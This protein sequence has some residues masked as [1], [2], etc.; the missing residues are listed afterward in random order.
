MRAVDLGLLGWQNRPF[1]GR[2]KMVLEM[3][4]GRTEVSGIALVIY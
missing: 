3:A 4:Y 1:L 2:N